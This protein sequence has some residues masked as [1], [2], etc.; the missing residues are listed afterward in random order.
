M[1][2]ADRLFQI[3]QILRRRKL[4]TAQRLAEELEVSGRTIYRDIQDLMCAG[5]PI[6]GEAGVG[7]VLRR[8]FD[9][10][11]LMFTHEELEALVL[12][13]RIVSSWADAALA[14]AAQDVLMKV[15]AVLPPQLKNRFAD[16]PLHVPDFHVPGGMKIALA[17]L[18]SAI[19]LR[20]KVFLEYVRAD[21]QPSERVVLPLGLFY[22]GATWTLAAWCELRDD[23]RN[24]RLDRIQQ[25][26]VLKQTFT[27]ESG[28]TL[29]DFF[30]RMAH[31]GR[32]E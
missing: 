10:P 25:L 32:C 12:G 1:R 22:W 27:D 28:R 9:L 11:P 26:A 17:P 3:I 5:V 16:S 23:F 13:S 30:Q 8:G 24:F 6:E 2:R 15:D 29:A 18:R 4:T 20:S 31:E 14:R 21:E 7:Y 19:A